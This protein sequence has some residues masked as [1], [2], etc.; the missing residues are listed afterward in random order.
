MTQAERQWKAVEDIIELKKVQ[1]HL[2]I[3]QAQI[4][5]RFSEVEHAISEACQHIFENTAEITLVDKAKW[6]GKTIV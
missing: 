3:E 4:C 2:I 6:L 1:D 5:A